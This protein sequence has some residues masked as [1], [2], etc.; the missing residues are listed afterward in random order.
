MLDIWLP[1]EGVVYSRKTTPSSWGYPT[2]MSQSEVA[3]VVTAMVTSIDAFKCNRLNKTLQ[4]DSKHNVVYTLSDIIHG[5]HY[6]EW[7]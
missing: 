1:E 3:V 6:I 2:M 4:T 5:M 7:L